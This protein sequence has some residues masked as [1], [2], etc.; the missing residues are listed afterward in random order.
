MTE[1][2]AASGTMPF[3]ILIDEAIR[4]VRRHARAILPAVA[5]PVAILSALVAVAQVGMVNLEGDVPPDDPMQALFPGCSM[6]LVMM[7]L[8]VLMGVAYIA[9]QTAAV[10]A[11]AGRPVDMGRAWRFAVRPAVW[12]TLILQ[13]LAVFASALLCLFPVLYVFPLL[14]FTVPAM[15]VENRFGGSALSRS[16]EL[17]R[18]NPQRQFFSTPLVKVLVFTLITTVISYALSMLVSLP[19]MIPMWFDVFR[20]ASAGAEPNVNVWLWLQVPAQFLSGLVS[21]AVSLYLGFGIALL[22]FDARNRR[23]GTDLAAAVDAIAPP[24]IVPPPPSWDAPR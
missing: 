9:L 6:L 12:G 5:I 17:T 14:S 18:Y 7:V 11:T 4:L 19:F 22:F 20:Q 21:T 2:Y 23:E 24:T 1:P 15:V 16:A 13:G 3:R 8:V 10:E